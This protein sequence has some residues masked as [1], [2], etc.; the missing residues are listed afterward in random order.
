MRKN[1]LD[2]SLNLLSQSGMKFV[3]IEGF[4]KY[5]FS[6]IAIGNIKVEKCILSN[7]SGEEVIA[8]LDR[9]ED[10]QSVTIE[11]LIE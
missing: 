8:H 4:K 9:F 11:G 1:S 2:N 3:I 10:F 7:P 6:K 5:S